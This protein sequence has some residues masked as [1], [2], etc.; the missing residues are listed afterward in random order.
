VFLPEREAHEAFD[1]I[2]TNGT[3]SFCKLDFFAAMQK[4]ASV[5]RAVLPDY[6]SSRL[7]TDESTYDAVDAAFAT[8]ANNGQRVTRKSFLAYV[9]RSRADKTPKTRAIR[10]IFDKIDVDGSGSISKLEFMAAMQQDADVNEF[11]LPGADSSQVMHSEW[12]FD[13][14][15]A[16]FEA[17]AAGK[18]RIEVADFERYFY[19]ATVS[20]TPMAKPLTNRSSRRV[21]IIGP[22]F[23][24]QLNPVQGKLIEAAGFQVH[25]CISVPNPEQPN[26]PV[27]L[28]LGQIMAEIDRFQ[29]DLVACASKGGVYVVALWQMGFWRGPTLLLNAHPS[30]KRLPENVPVVLAQGANDEVYPTSRA[31]LERLVST[32]SPNMS[33]LYYTANSG[34]IS[35]GMLTRTGDY[36]NQESLLLND[37][38][39]RLIDAA[40]APEGPEVHM[41]RTWRHQRSQERLEAERWLGLRPER[42]RERWSS[43][44]RR[45]RDE[46]VLFE[47][48][49]G[50]DEFQHVAAV[51]KAAPAE[52]EAY[53]LSPQEEWDAVQVLRVERIE[54]GPQQDGGFTPYCENVYQAF[55]AQSIKFEAGVHT[56]WAFHGADTTATESI[57]TNQVAGFQPLA[58]GSRNAALWGSGTYFARDAHYVADSHFCGSPASDGTRQMLMCLIML[59]MPCVGD[60]Q[61]RGVL[62]FRQKPHRY[63]STVDS[64]SCP[65]IYILQHPGAAYPA[66]LITFA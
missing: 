10:H 26:F 29:P 48:P 34:E 49:T 65:E 37:C 36:H 64:L 21:F 4:D 40:L 46:R 25:W 45:G 58:S 61:H 54:N 43:R 27:S 53:N 6:D 19:R 20:A 44:G 11:V 17:I 31:D 30:C 15:D 33:F 5:G 24:L 18:K 2:A 9:R 39:P 55:A 59:G 35:P 41:V 63:N 28:Y 14:V 50:S 8:M 23:A 3:D 16:A 52:K 13:A 22:G 56:C 42:L 7:L 60:P 1:R 62:P 38:L 51:F 32:G 66:Y 57:V 47:I 12:L